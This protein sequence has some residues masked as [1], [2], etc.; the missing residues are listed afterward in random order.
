MRT[1]VWLGLLVACG[2]APQE[3][4]LATHRTRT[5]S[6]DAASSTPALGDVRW[7][8]V[9]TIVHD[10]SVSPGRVAAVLD[11][12]SI[13]SFDLATGARSITRP[14]DP[15]APP[16]MPSISP[17]GSMI[18]HCVGTEVS[19]INIPLGTY[20]NF[21]HEGTCSAP[22]LWSPDAGR[23]YSILEGGH[24]AGF[25][26]ATGAIIGRADVLVD[27]F[28]Q[29]DGTIVSQGDHRIVELDGSLRPIAS[30]TMPETDTQH[31]SP[32]TS[33]LLEAVD[34]STFIYACGDASYDVLLVHD[35]V[36]QDLLWTS[37]QNE[38]WSEV[39]LLPN[40]RALV[41]VERDEAS[42]AR[43][44]AVRTGESLGEVP[45]VSH[46]FDVSADGTVA[47]AGIGARIAIIGLH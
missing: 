45:D 8:E 30:Y 14:S 16:T 40:E 47:A 2:S 5:P 11:D 35:G 41:L 10:V 34:H 36:Q 28:M 1:L 9:G 4:T 23:L 12:G 31:G 42:L 25:D 22:A 33:F 29:P 43:I 46:P 39:F 26:L 19:V 18:A 13:V 7:I 21:D 27:A 3:S 32:G 15:A 38:R 44:I 6:T 20:G 17:D 24:M 37:P